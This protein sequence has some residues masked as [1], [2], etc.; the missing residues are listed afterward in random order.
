MIADYMP[1]FA[2]G[3][4][5]QYRS[6]MVAL[7]CNTVRGAMTT[8]TAGEDDRILGDGFAALAS[9]FRPGGGDWDGKVG[10][11]GFGLR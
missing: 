4:L 2:L 3:T 7:L 9:V 1:I 8:G 5:Y 11:G 6:V 10:R